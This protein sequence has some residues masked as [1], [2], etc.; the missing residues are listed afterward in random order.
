MIIDNIHHILYTLFKSIDQYFG[1]S[2]VFSK[3]IRRIAKKSIFLYFAPIIYNLH[4]IMATINNINMY[5]INIRV[6]TLF[7]L[8]QCFLIIIIIFLI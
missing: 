2:V 4:G 3:V 8:N 6:K 1:T 7:K 5:I